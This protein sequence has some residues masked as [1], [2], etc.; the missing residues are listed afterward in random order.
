M[1][2]FVLDDD[3]FSKNF[4]LSFVFLSCLLYCLLSFILCPQNFIAFLRAEKKN[5]AKKNLAWRYV[6]LCVLLCLCMCCAG[7]AVC[8]GLGL[9]CVGLLLGDS[10]VLCCVWCTGCV[11]FALCCCVVFALCCVV[12]VCGV[13]SGCAVCV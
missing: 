2:T 12:F 4:V 3:S 5:L 10:V 1:S 6:V 7:C 11:V 13:V 8:L 9:L